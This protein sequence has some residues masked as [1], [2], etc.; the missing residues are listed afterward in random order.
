MNFLFCIKNR[1]MK[2]I[3]KLNYFYLIILI[4]NQDNSNEVR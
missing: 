1:K 3:L 4:Y 2:K